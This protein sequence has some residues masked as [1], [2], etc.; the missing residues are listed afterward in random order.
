[1]P[2]AFCAAKLVLFGSSHGTQWHHLPGH[3]Q[4]ALQ[5]LS[6]KFS[7]VLQ[8][9]SQGGASL[10]DQR[11]ALFRE[12]LAKLGNEAGV[13]VVV[14]L[15]G[16]NDLRE[17]DEPDV[18]VAKFA[19]LI[20]FAAQFL[21]LKLVISAIVPQQHQS[22]LDRSRFMKCTHELR[23]LCKLHPQA[24]FFN[25]VRGL[26]YMGEPREEYW[27]DAIHLNRQGAQ[28]VANQLKEVLRCL[29]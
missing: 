17:G 20:E 24:T 22:D 10:T 14:F 21:N 5:T 29:K 15:L 1:M 3:I 11:M 28:V 23:S 2:P 9:H 25:L 6:P 18:V 27:E 16:G 26:L 19:Q 13:R 8:N 12:L 4:T 7:G